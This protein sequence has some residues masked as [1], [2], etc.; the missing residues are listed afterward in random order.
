MGITA[1]ELLRRERGEPININTGG[2]VTIITGD[3]EVQGGRGVILELSGGG[4]SSKNTVE[5]GG[6]AFAEREGSVWRDLDVDAN[7]GHN[8][9]HGPNTGIER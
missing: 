3:A 5:V 6:Q 9:T 2:D 7:S 8:E 4:S 1:E